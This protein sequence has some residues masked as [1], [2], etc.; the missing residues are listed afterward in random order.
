M[1]EPQ[2]ARMWAPF[3]AYTFFNEM[4]KRCT[5]DVLFILNATS[6][7][8]L[9]TLLFDSKTWYAYENIWDLNLYRR[10]TFWWIPRVYLTTIKQNKLHAYNRTK[11]L[12]DRAQMLDTCF[13]SCLLSFYFWKQYE[14]RNPAQDVSYIC[15]C[16]RFWEECWIE[17]VR[18]QR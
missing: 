2:H 7:D 3:N 10:Y 15:K 16:K 14:E 13:A 5:C 11:L 8:M 4:K 1:C 12:A 18:R 17:I 9:L 6:R